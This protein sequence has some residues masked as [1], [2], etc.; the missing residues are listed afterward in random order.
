MMALIGTPCGTLPVGIDDRALRRRRREPGVGMRRGFAPVLRPI[1]G[2]QR[3]P[4]QSRHSAG[5]SGVIPSHHTPP[6]GVSATLV[7][8]VFRAMVAIAF[9]LVVARRARRHAEHA[10]F[11]IDRAQPSVGVGL[12]PGDVVADHRHLPALHR[13]GR[14]QH[15]QIRLAAG[16]RKRGGDVGLLALRILD[17]EDQHVLGHPA[18]VARDVRGD[19]QPEALLA[20]QRVAAVAGAVRPDLAR[21]REMDDVLLRVARPG[22]VLLPRRERR[23]DAVHARHHALDVLVDLAQHRQADAR[24]DPHADDDVRANR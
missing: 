24:H 5:G 19:A 1:S 9:G 8:I 16:A 18:L 10:G 22:H 17:A 6:S 20:E 12:D 14:D 15:R 3:S 13:L 23:A 21:L 4:R 7:K 2:V 11:G